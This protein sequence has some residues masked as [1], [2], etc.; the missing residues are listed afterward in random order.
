VKLAFLSAA[1]FVSGVGCN[2][3]APPTP[4]PPPEDPVMASAPALPGPEQLAG[5]WTLAGGAEQCEVRLSLQDLAVTA[6]SLA[7]PMMAAHLSDSCSGAPDISGW[8]PIPMGLE[9]TDADGRAVVVFQQTGQGVFS[10]I[11]QAWRLTPA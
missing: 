3:A 11:D 1:L 10:S 2:E 4:P 9:L 7:A 5:A 8:R 6:G